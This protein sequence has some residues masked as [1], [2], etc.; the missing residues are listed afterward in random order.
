MFF[1]MV[2]NI[3]IAVSHRGNLSSL[4]GHHIVVYVD[5][6]S[7]NLATAG[8]TGIT[9]IAAGSFWLLAW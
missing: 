2:I 6:G 4:T 9:L 8:M 3:M 5:D 1:A 7:G